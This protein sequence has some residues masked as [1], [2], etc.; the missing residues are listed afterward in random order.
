VGF[1]EGHVE[2]VEAGTC[3]RRV[4]GG[5]GQVGGSGVVVVVGV[6]GDG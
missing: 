4:G 3:R 5:G 2:V 1:G 6:D